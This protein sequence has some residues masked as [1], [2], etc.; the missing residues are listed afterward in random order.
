M[1]D[2]DE[3]EREGSV[4]TLVPGVGSRPCYA[5]IRVMVYTLYTIIVRCVFGFWPVAMERSEENN[6]CKNASMARRSSN[7]KQVHM[8]KK[9]NKALQCS[10]AAPSVQQKTLLLSSTLFA[11]KGSLGDLDD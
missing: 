9:L 4:Q 10:C 5:L 2:F 8:V 1:V 6:I 7:I 11:V 3:Q